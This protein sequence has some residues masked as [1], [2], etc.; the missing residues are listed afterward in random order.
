[1]RM[2]LPDVLESLSDFS[3]GP[4][5]QFLNLVG[6]IGGSNGSDTMAAFSSGFGWANLELPA[7]LAVWR[8]QPISTDNETLNETKSAGRRAKIKKSTEGCEVKD[9]CADAEDDLVL[10]ESC[11]LL[12]L[13]PSAEKLGTCIS[14]LCSVFAIR[15][16]LCLV[17]KH[18]LHKDAPS[19]FMF[20]SWVVVFPL[21]VLLFDAAHTNDQTRLDNPYKCK[22][23]LTNVRC[24]QSPCS[25]LR[26][27]A[28]FYSHVLFLTAFELP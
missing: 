15:S 21:P 3:I 25:S 12:N 16:T 8:P 1:M 4:P 22:L 14:L 9:D 6:R 24:S 28:S 11:S 5:V 23:L 19:S 13:L 17:F 10:T 27:T 2:L 20:P 7:S 18:C 26:M